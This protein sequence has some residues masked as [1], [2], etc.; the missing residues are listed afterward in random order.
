MN[1]SL[2]HI[3]AYLGEQIPWQREN[4][5]AFREVVHQVEPTVVEEWKWGVPVFMLGKTLVCAMSSF[6]EHTK[7]NF[8]EGAVL[9]DVHRLFNSGLD[10]KKHRSI[11][12]VEG[13]VLKVDHLKDLV[14]V[15]FQ[16]AK[17]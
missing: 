14:R 15:A 6:K 7:F 4:L 8:F 11:N 12:L 3:E 1:T 16:Y 13:E 5:V 17:K 2:E 10:S 9:E